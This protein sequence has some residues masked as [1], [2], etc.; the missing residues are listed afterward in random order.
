M[1]LKYW[2][3]ELQFTKFP[4]NSLRNSRLPD[5]QIT[6]LGGKVRSQHFLNLTSQ[7]AAD[8]FASLPI[9]KVQ[10][11]FPDTSLPDCSFIKD[12]SDT[13]NLRHD[14][15]KDWST[16]ELKKSLSSSFS[17][18]HSS[19]RNIFNGLSKRATKQSLYEEFSSLSL[20]SDSLGKII[21]FST[22]L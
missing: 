18:T 10:W 15:A 9:K 5:K 4:R 1:I 14:D 2:I 12:L 17:L 21:I 7:C 19:Y 11:T 3:L 22:L 16:K 20:R 8:E 13:S 6:S